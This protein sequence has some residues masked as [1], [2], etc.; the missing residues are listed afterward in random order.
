MSG[1]RLIRIGAAAL[2]LVIAAM[3]V[4]VVPTIDEAE[5]ANIPTPWIVTAGP[6][7]GVTDGQSISINV[8]S[9]IEN[10]IASAKAQICRAG[11]DYSPNFESDP[12]VDF[13]IGGVNCPS[14]PISTS[15]D[16]TVTDV[17][18]AANATRPGGQTFSMF[19][20]VGSVDWQDNDGGEQSLTCDALNPCALVV[21]VRG[22]DSAGDFRWIPTVFTVEYLT[23]DPIAGC[24]GPADGIISS[25][26][27]D[28]LLQAW[29]ATTL[30][31]CKRPGAQS[32][33]ATAQSFAGEGAA[34]DSFSRKEIDLVYSGAGYDPRVELGLGRADDPLE[35]RES[36]AIPIAL[37]AAVLAIGNGKAG[38]NGNKVP[39]SNDIMF[40]L[41]EVTAM[42]T[43]GPVQMDEHLGPI[44]QR[45][46]ELATTG[47]FNPYSSISV[48][49]PSEAESTSWF[50]TNHLDQ[51]RP[52]GWKV[53]DVGAFGPEAGLSRGAD[54]AFALASPSF[55]GVLDLYSGRT[56]LDKTIK[57]MGRDSYGGVYSIVD[58][59]TAL[60]LNMAPI[61]IENADG[62]FV[63]PTAETMNA[64][65]PLMERTADG[66]LMPAPDM[67]SDSDSQ[68]YPM[69]Y[70]VYAIAPKAALVDSACVPRATSQKL[71]ADWLT[72][73]TT[74]GQSSLGLGLEPLP[75][76][77]Q[78]EAAAAI[79]Q[80]GTGANDCTPAATA[81]PDGSGGGT[82]VAPSASG[83]AGRGAARTA[84]VAAT[85]T[86]AAAGGTQVLA[87][88][89][90]ASALANMGTFTDGSA[91]SGLLA[92][93]GLVA[94]FGLLVVSA[95]ATS[96]KL[97]LRGRSG[98]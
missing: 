98:K 83:V 23:N 11:V 54:A 8:T 58:R 39:Y 43:G 38:P 69:T 42:V 67:R 4:T 91:T 18:V 45:N 78:A 44:V 10:P 26:S 12:N 32:G 95:M 64:A 27:S 37:N 48:G 13:A 66:R 85:G 29:I 71:L 34:M 86:G 19:A 35:A 46:P 33:A 76:G 80:V 16:L 24:G 74:D 93:G 31:Q 84:V 81:A 75:A 53:P 20:G 9:P 88:A 73:L 14:I 7:T 3:T 22:T 52:D 68:V 79:A 17:G 49:A 94:V 82:V 90:L 97:N 1:N 21:Q 70:V 51:L 47:I 41:D 25:G 62:D 59:A 50:F 30:D 60:A 65:V 40:T 56:I 55:Q 6:L 63:A 61:K 2:V 87:D 72:Y 36:V 89:E 28:S 96:G 15:A 57:L 77:L 5:A 92:I